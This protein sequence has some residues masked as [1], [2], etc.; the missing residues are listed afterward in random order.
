[1]LRIRTL[2]WYLVLIE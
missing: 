1:M 2:S